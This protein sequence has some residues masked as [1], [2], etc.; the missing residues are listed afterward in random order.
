MT[1]NEMREMSLK[2]TVPKW[3]SAHAIAERSSV[4]LVRWYLHGVAADG[5]GTAQRE[6]RLREH[7]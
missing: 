4:P 5:S 1:T 3:T 7:T 6:R 2:A